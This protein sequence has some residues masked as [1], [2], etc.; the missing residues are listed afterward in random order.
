MWRTKH[1]L[2]GLFIF[3]TGNL[4]FGHPVAYKGA[5]SLMAF[6]QPDMQDWQVLYTV[7]RNLSLGVD[8]IHDTM[9]GT[10]RFYLVP[11]ISWLMKRWNGEDYQA[12]I[13]VVGGA[14]GVRKDSAIE[15]VGEGSVEADYETRKVYV[16]GKA[17]VIGAKNTDTLAVYQFRTG[18]AP[19]AG[20]YEGLNAWLIGQ[21]QYFPFSNEESVRV[22]PVLRLFYQN[23]LWEVGVSARGTWNFNFMV[24]F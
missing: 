9:S 2:I 5:V 3:L 23:V 4:G 6:N 19:Y 22:G 1:N 13:Y 12:N 7:A 17:T 15:L 10:E 20:E 24:H 14:G 18:F 8:Y 11:R 16:S 21:V